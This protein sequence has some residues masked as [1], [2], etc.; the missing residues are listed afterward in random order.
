MSRFLIFGGFLA[1]IAALVAGCGQPAATTP[2]APP[3]VPS[4]SVTLVDADITALDAVMNER[5][6]KVI[7]VD[8]WAK[9]CPP[10]RAR[11]PHFVDT[12]NK[13]AAKG[14]VCISVSLDNEG[15][16][17]TERSEVLEFLTDK[18]ASFPNFLL[19]G[20]RQDAEKIGRRFGFAGSLP[21]VALFGKD[22]NK[23]WD[24]EQRE[25]KDAELD[26]LIETELAK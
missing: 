22:G 7:L 21:F 25:L 8:F 19:T 26:K 15:R 18:G 17:P 10:C 12:H 5:K 2:A 1:A 11:F 16:K 6:G 4:G 13:F 14:L 9:W 23:V 3:P 20:Y 24:V